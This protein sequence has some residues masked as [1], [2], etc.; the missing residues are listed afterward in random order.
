MSRNYRGNAKNKKVGLLS[1]NHT[2]R[3]NYCILDDRLVDALLPGARFGNEEKNWI[4]LKKKKHEH[5]AIWR[6]AH[7]FYFLE[8]NVTKLAIF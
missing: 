4:K 8:L 1:L 3:L 5:V 7:S 6:A 2:L